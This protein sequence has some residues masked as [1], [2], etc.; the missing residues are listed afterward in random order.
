MQQELHAQIR[1][2]CTRVALTLT[3]NQAPSG[4]GLLLYTSWL[5]ACGMRMDDV[6]QTCVRAVC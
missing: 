5:T 6:A 4:E 2:R 1:A 3:A